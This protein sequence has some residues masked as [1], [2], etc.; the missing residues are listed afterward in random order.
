[1]SKSL[2]NF[3][4]VREAANVYGYEN[5]R[6]F[7]LMSHYRSPLNYS[8]DVLVQAKNALDR[9]KT[10]KNTLEF[11]AANGSSD[12]INESA[13]APDEARNNEKALIDSLPRYRERFIES[14]D[15]DFNTA[16][17]VSVIFELV[18]ESNTVAAG[19]A[20]SKAFAKAALE[21]LDELTGVLG[22]LYTQK[23]ADSLDAG[24]EALIAARQDARKAKDW[25]QA[26]IIRNKL[27]EMGIILEDTPQGVRW[28]RK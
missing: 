15:D 18:R 9:I 23:D 12:G 5:I 7:I 14:L 2:G 19:P 4:T 1:M 16:D 21:V 27:S 26:D 10:A 8:G 17:A 11:I 28:S 24:V 20:P 22:L 13:A 3:F 6:M 25:A